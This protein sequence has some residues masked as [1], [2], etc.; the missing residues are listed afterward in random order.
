M[1]QQECLILKQH[2]NLQKGIGNIDAL[3]D[4]FVEKKQSEAK[5]EEVV[6]DVEDE[7]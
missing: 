7:Y 1:Y 4:Q 5:K 6:G 2:E 3:F